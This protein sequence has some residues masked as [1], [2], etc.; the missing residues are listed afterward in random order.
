MP[1]IFSHAV[2]AVALGTTFAALPLSAD[3]QP[4]KLPA[5]FW[6]LSAACAMLPDADVIAF[7]FGIRY[8][9]VL[10]HRGLSHS[11][12]FA[13][14]L[15]WLVVTIFFQQTTF[16]KGWLWFYFFLATISHGCLDALTNG[17]LGVAFF[18]PIDDTRYFFPWQPI[19]VSPIG[20]SFF[21]ARGAVVFYNELLWIWFPSLL[22]SLFSLIARQAVTKKADDERVL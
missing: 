5:R 2:A 8:S 17:G 6:G 15:G 21:S 4:V 11:I 14:L 7:A 22:V 1:T 10:G 3:R 12:L 20:A 13:I 9:D 16:R 19:E 18:T